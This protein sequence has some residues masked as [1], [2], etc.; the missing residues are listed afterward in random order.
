MA[1]CDFFSFVPKTV[2]LSIGDETLH[3]FLSHTPKCLNIKL[4]VLFFDEQQFVLFRRVLLITAQLEER[5]KNNFPTPPISPVWASS[6]IF[7]NF[8]DKH[9]Q[10]NNSACGG[11]VIMLNRF[12]ACNIFSMSGILPSNRR[13]W[14][15]KH[16]ELEMQQVHRLEILHL[17]SSV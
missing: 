1:L 5:K 16:N 13:H 15:A 9:T 17:V 3:C 8:G 10:R 14:P 4:S 6:L 12:I 11:N 7:C 2:N